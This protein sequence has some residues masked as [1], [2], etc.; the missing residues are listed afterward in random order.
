MHSG[1]A[2][3]KQFMRM[4]HA[5]LLLMICLGALTRCSQQTAADNAVMAQVGELEI[6]RM[7][8]E[9]AL[10]RKYQSPARVDS[11][12]SLEKQQVLHS[13]IEQKL[14]LNEALALG[15]DQKPLIREKIENYHR[16]ML[17]N[18]LVERNVVDS[19]LTAERL[20][21]FYAKYGG[22]IRLQQIMIP[23]TGQP[24]DKNAGDG[25]AA[26][27]IQ[28]IYRMLAAGAD[29][30]ETARKY[31]AD[32]RSAPR[33]GDLG[34]LRWGRLPKE[35]QEVAFS[36][37]IR[38]ISPPVRSGFGY[39]I[40]RV[41]ERKKRPFAQE[42]RTIKYQLAAVYARTISNARENYFFRLSQRYHARLHAG[43]ISWLSNAIG[44]YYAPWQNLDQEAQQRALAT[45]DGGKVTVEDL[46]QH[47][48]EKAT[49]YHWMQKTIEK[50]VRDI[51]RQAIAVAEAQRQGIEVKKELRRYRDEQLV[52]HLTDLK[53]AHL[54]EPTEAEMKAYYQQHPER[55][56]APAAV[57]VREI[58]VD[59]LY[60]A[61]K[62]AARLKQ[63]DDF[64]AL[65]Q[66][67][68]SRSAKQQKDGDLGFV[69]AA[70]HPAL[71]AAAQTMNPGEFSG[72][73]TV[74]EGF[75]VIQVLE[76]RPARKLAMNEARPRVRILLLKEIRD[77]LY[78]D[79]VQTLRQKYP[80]HVKA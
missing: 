56:S 74:P 4:G 9:A 43:N 80:V 21:E 17:I 79:W 49:S 27:R 76:K 57:H 61:E 73:V 42:V 41:L 63:G 53:L 20:R 25:D 18:K 50:F 29:F 13:L 23:A 44:P 35:V 14:I 54:P 19:I 59:D 55:F 7:E 22:E 77:R 34:Y 12:S 52:Q 67:Y 38:E 69:V 6:T 65:Q 28:E 11:L 33:G 15:L 10:Q 26:I 66:Q 39:Y 75:S 30:A 3:D 72:P 62:I 40:V 1:F 78:R 5:F 64:A 36:L 45:Y 71:F 58:L 31:S 2:F 46:I 32:M 16:T 51:C 60:L 70:Q 68:N 24:H 48:G 8:F 47:A 37:P